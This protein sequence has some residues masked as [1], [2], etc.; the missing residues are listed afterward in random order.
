MP[1][2][3]RPELSEVGLANVRVDKI[4]LAKVF[5]CFIYACFARYVSN[6]GQHTVCIKCKGVLSTGEYRMVV[7]D[8][9]GVG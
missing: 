7:G 1:H 9:A 6:L 3:T 5:K 2:S 8:R 4:K